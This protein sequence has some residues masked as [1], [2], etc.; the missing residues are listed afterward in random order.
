MKIFFVAI[1]QIFGFINCA[2]NIQSD[3][4]IKPLHP[5]SASPF[6][7][8]STVEKKRNF[9]EKYFF[10]SNIKSNQGLMDSVDSFVAQLYD[11]SKIEIEE[12]GRFSINFYRETEVIN[13]NF[14]QEIDGMISYN[15]LENYKDD[16]LFTYVWI[17]GE[18][19]GCNLLK[20]GKVIETR[21]P[22]NSNA[23]KSHRK[24]S[25]PVDSIAVQIEK[26]N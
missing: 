22:Q 21:F 13:E 8:D 23:F 16:L 19:F 18:F 5:Y 7:Y 14:R 1:I 4:K 9:I 3:F 6:D 10:I 2:Q 12:Y 20:N 15:L 26:V 24:L 11:K 25:I 17:D